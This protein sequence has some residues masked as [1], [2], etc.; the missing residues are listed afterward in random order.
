M[1]KVIKTID[2]I[3]L[4]H[5]TSFFAH[6]LSTTGLLIFSYVNS[7]PLPLIFIS[8]FLNLFFVN[9]LLKFRDK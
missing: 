3:L 4:S 5:K 1:K 9:A 6:F 2:S 7:S 8:L